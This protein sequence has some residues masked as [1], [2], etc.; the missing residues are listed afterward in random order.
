MRAIFLGLSLVVLASTALVGCSVHSLEGVASNKDVT[1]NLKLVESWRLAPDVA[2][3][4]VCL[5]SN[6][7]IFITEDSYPLCLVHEV[8]HATHGAWH[9]H[10][11]P[12]D[13]FYNK[14]P[15]KYS[16]ISHPLEAPAKRNEVKIRFKLHGSSPTAGLF[17]ESVCRDGECNTWILE[18]H[19]PN[20]VV[21]LFGHATHGDWVVEPKRECFK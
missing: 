4:A 11:V 13:C 18:N 20:C 7:T 3:L 21:E 15:L 19:Y 2:G 8:G 17:G 14:L 10:S 9:P 12:T 5:N 16:F 6:C 1:I